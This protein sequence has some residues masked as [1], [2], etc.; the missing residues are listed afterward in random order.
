MGSVTRFTG[1]PEKGIQL[2]QQLADN[3]NREWF[4]EHKADFDTHLME[5]AR[6]FVA[7]MGERLREISPDIIADP[8][9]DKSIFRM[10]RD[11]RFTKDKSPYKTHLGILFWEGPR[12]KMECPGFY[13]HLEPPHLMLAAGMHC[14][15]R[16]VL[17][18]YRDS[19]VDPKHGK[20]LVKSVKQVTDGAGYEVGGKNYKKTPRGYDAKHPNAEFLLYDGLYAAI[21]NPVP[22][23]LHSA[24][25]LDYCFDRF[26]G[27]FPIHRWLRDLAQRAPEPDEAPRRRR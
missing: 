12:P 1:F 11:T 5:P 16:P 3:N 26:T 4:T 8:R 19:V 15:S 10:Y 24:Q 14:F 17:Q 7:D 27:M 25:L 22:A 23:E 18:A 20:A 9:T 2:L 6:L 13:F 21:T